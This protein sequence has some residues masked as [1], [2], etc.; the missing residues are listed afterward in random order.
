MATYQKSLQKIEVTT[1]R[2][3]TYTAQDTVDRMIATQALSEFLSEKPM[4]I[5]NDPK[6]F[7]PFEAVELVEVTHSVGSFD[8][9]DAYCRADASTVC[10]AKACEANTDC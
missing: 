2:G 6:D 8:R 1:R 7:I 5:L 3:N 9:E 4:H 10:D